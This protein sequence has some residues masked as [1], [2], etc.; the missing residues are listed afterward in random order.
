LIYSKIPPQFCH[1]QHSQHDNLMK[2]G[3]QKS[4]CINVALVNGVL[5]RNER[6]RV[7]TRFRELPG[8]HSCSS[9]HNLAAKLHVLLPLAARRDGSRMTGG[10][11]KDAHMVCRGVKGPAAGAA[12]RRATR[13]AG[14]QLVGVRG[15]VSARGPG[16]VVIDVSRLPG[17][18][19]H[20][21]RQLS[22]MPTQRADWLV[23]VSVRTIKRHHHHRR[24]Q[25]LAAV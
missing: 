8:E 7:F 22:I 18:V 24:A 5:G 19:H 23:F 3:G 11:N 12:R 25:G 15:I 1:A 4:H 2:V 13:R 21:A 9:W 16:I 6:A 14:Q 17:R 20:I 10:E